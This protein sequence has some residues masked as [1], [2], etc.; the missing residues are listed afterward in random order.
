[1]KIVLTPERP[2]EQA[3]DEAAQSRGTTAELLALEVLRKH[4]LG[5]E[6]ARF[7]AA[8]AKTLADLLEGCVGLVPDEG[9]PQGPTDFAKRSSELFA[10]D[11]V[12]RWERGQ[13]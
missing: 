5:S 4:F 11:L 7:D 8:G 12:Q 9:Y 10:R 6:E 2:L 13:K 3:I 1:M